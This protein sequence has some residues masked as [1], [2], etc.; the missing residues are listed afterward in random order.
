MINSCTASLLW[1]YI[2]IM[3]MQNKFILMSYLLFLVPFTLKAS[4]PTKM[5]HIEIG[6]GSQAYSNSLNIPNGLLGTDFS[7]LYE[8][9]SVN[10][11]QLGKRYFLQLD[12]SLLNKQNLYAPFHTYRGELG[13]DRTWAIVN[14]SKFNL[15]GGIGSSFFAEYCRTHK[16]L[17]YAREYLEWSISLNALFNCEY[18]LNQFSIRYRI[19]LPIVNSGFFSEYARYEFGSIDYYLTPNQVNT[20]FDYLYCSNKLSI[21]YR[22]TAKQEIS[23]SYDFIYRNSFVFENKIN[24]IQNH[25]LLGYSY[26]Y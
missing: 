9:K 22:L 4:S 2:N 11:N 12:Y 21:A 3:P 25:F 16:Q 8:H 15:K 23:F 24:N 7:F 14:T 10:A 1:L 6:R 5:H 17:F 20:C 19:G 18:R 26:L 13:V